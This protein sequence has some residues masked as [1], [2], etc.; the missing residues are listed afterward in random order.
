MLICKVISSNSYL[1]SIFIKCLDS[2]YNL[3][4]YYNKKTKRTEKKKKNHSVLS[5]VYYGLIVSWVAF[6]EKEL[7]MLCIGCSLKK[8]FN[9]NN[10]AINIRK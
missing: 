4:I 8:Y 1:K 9:G 7:G 5:K 6:M 10:M 2:F 3:Q